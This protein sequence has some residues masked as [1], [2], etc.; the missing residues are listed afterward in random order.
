MN[1]IIGITGLKR[2]GKDTCANILMNEFNFQKYNLADPIRR[3]CSDI[4]LWDYPN[5]INGEFKETVDPEWGIS[6]RQAMQN[7]GTEWGQYSLCKHYEEFFHVTGRLLWVKRFCRWWKTSYDI[8]NFNVVIPDIRFFHE[9][10]EIQN[11]ID[12]SIQ[13]FFIRINRNLNQEKDLHESERH[14][15]NLPVDWEIDNNG[16]LK[17]FEENCFSTFSLIGINK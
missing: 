3:A 17:E 6:P 1:Y 14:I 11:S 12:G 5:L 16:T 7:L 10:E 8:H 15:V 13:K 4:F 2:S 9:I